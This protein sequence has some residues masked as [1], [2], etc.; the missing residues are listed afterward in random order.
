MDKQQSSRLSFS[1]PAQIQARLRISKAEF[2]RLI[3]AGLLPE[4]I[5]LTGARATAMPD[6]ETDAIAVARTGGLSALVASSA[7]STLSLAIQAHF[8]VKRAERLQGPLALFLLTIADSGERKSTIDN[9]FT[10]AIRWYQQE[11]AEAAKPILKDYKAAIAA[12]EAKHAGIKD[13]IRALAKASKS[14]VAAEADLRILEREKPKQPRVPRLLY[15]DATPEALA[16]GLATQWPSGGVVSAEAGIVFGGHAMSKDSVMRN[17]GLLNVIWDGNS[18]RIDRRTSE[19]F[20]VQGARLT[21]AL[22]I[23]EAVLREFL[24]RS[25]ALARGSGFLARFCLAWPVSTQGMRPFTEP[26][27][28]WPQLAAF[29]QRIAA[30]LA[31]PIPID[32]DGCLTPTMLSMTA[33][34]K[35]AWIEH[36]DHVESLLASGGELCNVRDVA[37][38]SADNA[39]RLAAL[40]HI[41]GSTN[42]VNSDNN[43]EFDD[44]ERASRIV[45]WHLS[46]SRRFFGELALPAE[47]ADA[48]RLDTWLIAYCQREKKRE[49]GKNYTRQHGPLRDGTALNAAIRELAGLDRVRLG[50]DGKRGTIQLN[51]ALVIEG[52][53][54]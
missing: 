6:H 38:K 5:T 8:D 21:M 30:I 51:P 33:A 24:T 18:L 22:Q 35:S 28:N 3:K 25:G 46:E 19:S 54:S 53:V 29:N 34:A 7:L 12:W 31:N 48:A 47:L 27:A 2:Y 26:P 16:Y 17:L 1:R 40:F 52:G 11:R 14:T 45:A 37:S 43:I 42:S 10:E 39:A 23:Q 20:T 13:N 9:L 50:K 44:V 15:A 41:F 4:L 49:V 36:H 32:D